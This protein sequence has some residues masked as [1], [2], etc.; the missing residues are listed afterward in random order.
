MNFIISYNHTSRRPS[1]CK[2][3]PFTLDIDKGFISLEEEDGWINPKGHNQELINALQEFFVA[4]KQNNYEDTLFPGSTLIV[5]QDILRNND[6]D[7]STTKK[8]VEETEQQIL[9][10]ALILHS[11][12]LTMNMHRNAGKVKTTIAVDNQS[13]LIKQVPDA[14]KN[15]KIIDKSSPSNHNENN[16]YSL[17]SIAKTALFFGTFTAVAITAVHSLISEKTGP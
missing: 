9:E 5:N 4:W 8:L 13:P 1:L 16:G 12:Q 6:I 14:E 2:A 3:R 10:D 15:H 7:S 17:Y 11:N